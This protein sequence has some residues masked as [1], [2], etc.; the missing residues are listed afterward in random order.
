MNFLRIAWRDIKSILKNRFIRVSIIAIIIVP[1]LYSLLY[2]AAF[3]DPYSKLKSVPVAVVNLDEGSTKDGKN[4]NY[5]EDIIKNLKKNNELGWKFTTFKDADSGTKGEKYYAEFIIP[6]NFSEKVISAKDKAPQKANILYRDNEKRNFIMSQVISKAQ[7]ALKDE[8]AKTITNEYTKITFDNLYDVKD[9]FKAAADGSKKLK[10]GVS[11]A[12]DGSMQLKDGIGQVKD[13]MPEIQSGT[14]KLYDGANKLVDG[15]NT[16]AVDGNGKPMGLKNG[17]QQLNNGLSQAASGV[18]AAQNQI[19]Q[20][21]GSLSGKQSSLAA[22]MNINNARALRG[23]MGDAGSLAQVDLSGVGKMLPLL[24]SNTTTVLYKASADLQDINLNAMMS[25]PQLAELMTT[26]NMTKVSKLLSDTQALSQADMSK[27]MPLV[28]LVGDSKQLNDLI[29]QAV[30]LGN[31][32]MTPI[33]SIAPLLNADNAQALNI[34]LQGASSNLGGQ[35]GKDK[36][37]FINAQ[38]DAAGEFAKN[39]DALNTAYNNLNNSQLSAEEKVAAEQQLLAQYNKFI[40]GTAAKMSSSAGKMDEMSAL[41]QNMKGLI[42]KNSELIKGTQTALQ[43]DNIKAVSGMLGTLGE[44]QAR[45][46]SPETQ[47]AITDV[48]GAMTPENMAYIS[49]LADKLF[50]VK[51]DLDQNKDNLAAVGKLLEAVKSDGGVQQSIGKIAK[52]QSDMKSAAPILTALNTTMNDPSIKA[53]L[54]NAPQLMNQ[55]TRIQRQLKDNQKLLE[56]AQNQLSDGNIQAAN[57]IIAQIPAMTGKFNELASGVSQLNDGS[58]DLVN[59][60]TVLS[61]GSSQIRDGIG[62]LNGGMPTLND[63]ANKLYNG[64]SDLNDGLSK[65]YDGSDELATKLQDGYDKINKNLVNTSSSM[66][67]FVSEPLTI[68]QNAI[69]EVKN[70]GMGF[71]PYFIPLS[72]WVGAIM[73]FFIITDKVDDDINASPRSIVA[74]KFL[75]YGYVGI[76]QAVLVSTVVLLLGLRPKSIIAYYLFNIFMSYVFIAIIQCLVFLMGMVGRLLSIVLLILQLT[77]CAGTFP[78]E[79][80]PNLFKV[81]NPFMPFTYCVSALREIIAGVNYVTLT[82]DVTILAVVMFV[83]LFISMAFKGHADKVQQIIKDKKDESLA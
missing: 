62:T 49:Q 76:M 59:G 33:K 19:S 6:Q 68:T 77:S 10:D 54:A 52:L 39:A 7:L 72:L 17:A 28:A 22:L 63:G 79:V 18:S 70:Y 40:A 15:I 11:S 47:K 5:G 41:L 78:L 71:T 14:Q 46:K 45:F 58:R 37:D 36:I 74:G 8:I 66:A 32:D 26:D 9:G 30:A 16:T 67:E 73:M 60:I 56:V 23:I 1:L 34:L 20:A 50:N 42:D 51:A 75:S 2:L 82:K 21:M 38:K 53:Q 35:N 83:F 3:W 61:S 57:G 64:S 44:A 13:K 65:I 80:T 81:L 25:M 31:M 24:N 48:Q 69:G 4:V 55:V 27:L 29:S 43:P 12:K